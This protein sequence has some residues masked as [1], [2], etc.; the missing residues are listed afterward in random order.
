MGTERGVWIEVGP[1]TPFLVAAESPNRRS[2]PP[3]PD[4]GAVVRGKVPS[5]AVAGSTLSL[6]Q[7]P[8]VQNLYRLL[9][10]PGRSD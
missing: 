7:I 10:H 1:A 2:N 3:V 8:S 5:T 6:Q 4:R 9:R